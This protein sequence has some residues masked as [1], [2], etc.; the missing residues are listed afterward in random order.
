MS[1]DVAMEGRS[2]L[3]QLKE[4]VKQNETS[5]DDDSQRGFAEGELKLHQVHGRC[6]CMAQYRTTV[7]KCIQTRQATSTATPPILANE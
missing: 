2:L 4:W 1:A 3:E 6:S 7:Q 5:D